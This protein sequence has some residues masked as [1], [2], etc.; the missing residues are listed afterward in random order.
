AAGVR[1]DVESRGRGDRHAAGGVAAD[2]DLFGR[3]DDEREGRRR[4]EGADQGTD[5]AIRSSH[6]QGKGTRSSM[7]GGSVMRA[8]AIAA[9]PLVPAAA[10]GQRS[11]VWRR[12]RGGGG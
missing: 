3:R 11:G 6:L 10:A 7:V 8:R 4:G 12:G 1:A 5:R 9:A 2:D